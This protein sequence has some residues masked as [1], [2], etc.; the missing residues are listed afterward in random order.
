VDDRRFDDLARVVSGSTSRRGML[1]AIAAVLLGAAG[2]PP[3]AR[4]AEE[5]DGGRGAPEGR[6]TGPGTSARRGKRRRNP[7]QGKKCPKCQRASTASAGR[8]R[9]ATGTA[10][11]P[12]A[13]A[14]TGTASATT[15]SAANRAGTASAAARPGSARSTTRAQLPGHLLPRRRALY[16]GRLLP[17]PAR[18]RRPLLPD[19]AD[20]RQLG[21]LLPGGQKCQG[22]TNT[23]C[24]PCKGD[25][26]CPAGETCIDPG[27][28][29]PNSCC[30]TSSNTPCGDNG[31]GT[32]QACCSNANEECC[33]GE[34]VTKGACPCPAARRGAT[35]DAATRRRR[36]ATRAPAGTSARSIR[37]ER[38]LQGGRRLLVLPPRRPVVLLPVRQTPL[39][40][41]RRPLGR[42][43]PSV[44]GCGGTSR[45]PGRSGARTA[46]GVGPRRLERHLE[47]R[48]FDVG[49]VTMHRFPHPP[50]PWRRCSPSRRRASAPLPPKRSTARSATPSSTTTATRR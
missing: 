48:T 34:C 37:L 3:A 8:T 35:A 2:L 9:R 16:R 11:A 21:R 33:N 40:R 44:G 5:G 39:L 38:H 36:S 24:K 1:G 7:C 14:T 45:Q 23:C 17:R 25:Q 28:F 26:C 42:R 27:V 22:R 12:A 50:P 29:A 20:L 47:A 13:S 15:R 31:D 43:R 4:G 18:R 49:G 10:V 30:N 19:R 41:S 32:F 6:S 46:A